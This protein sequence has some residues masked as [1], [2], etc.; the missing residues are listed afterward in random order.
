M[1][2]WIRL[3]CPSATMFV[4]LI[5]FIPLPA[6]GQTSGAISG[7]VT[8]TGTSTPLDGIMVY[9]F[10]PGTS[11]GFPLFAFA[12]E[13]GD[14]TITGLDE[15]EYVVLAYSSGMNYVAEY[16]DDTI[17]YA[18]ADT[19]SVTAGENTP[20]IDFELSPG[21]MI[22]GTVTDSSGAGISNIQISAYSSCYGTYLN[23]A[24]PDAEGAY[25]IMGLPA[26]SV[27]LQTMNDPFGSTGYVEEWYEDAVF[28]EDATPVTVSI[29]VTTEGIDLQV[30]PA[31]SISGTV[32]ESDGTT[33]VA[34]MPVA[35]LSDPCDSFSY[36][37][38]LTNES[39]VY[40]IRGL[41]P[42][43]VYVKTSN[44]M[45]ANLDRPEKNYL[46][47]WYDGTFSCEEATPVE[48]TAGVN[49]ADVNF[50]LSDD[51]DTDGDEMPDEWESAYFG[52]ISR[53]GSQDYDE[54]GVTDLQEYLEGTDPSA[55]L[56]NPSSG[57]G[58]GGGGCFISS[59]LATGS[60]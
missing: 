34:D 37:G 49:T 15:G 51:T 14:Y 58:G 54:D 8:E 16:Y 52:G 4:L 47:E 24:R 59:V 28:C 30:E 25:T 29:G 31:G 7:T 20:N 60:D 56:D 10:I 19:V 43:I 26:G 11:G 9:A 57:G 3:L 42:D 41:T 53:D 40:S 21:G 1:E 46:R 17:H 18:E 2:K 22:S 50:L 23:S 45:F 32:Y 44:D 36:I 12:D 38:T 39:G 48:I 13:Y 35:V 27:Y 33:P 5:S 55:T 6:A